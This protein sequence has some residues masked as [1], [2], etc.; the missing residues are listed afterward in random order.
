MALGVCGAEVEGGEGTEEEARLL[1]DEELV[2][3][4]PPPP[5]RSWPEEEEGAA[6]PYL[7]ERV[8]AVA[9][10]NFISTELAREEPEEDLEEEDGTGQAG[11][12]R[13]YL[14]F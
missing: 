14:G 4:A 7:A 2:A 11:S 9:L 10:E 6:P 1:P 5:A 3:P 8:P 13:E 12:R